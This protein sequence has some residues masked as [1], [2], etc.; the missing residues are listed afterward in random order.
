MNVVFKSFP[1]N[2]HTGSCQETEEAIERWFSFVEDYYENNTVPLSQVLC[3]NA[4]AK[5]G[6]DASWK[7]PKRELIKIGILAGYKDEPS[8]GPFIPSKKALDSLSK[9]E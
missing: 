3:S 7:L 4:Y 2:E 8:A 1:S 5:S 6:V 9:L